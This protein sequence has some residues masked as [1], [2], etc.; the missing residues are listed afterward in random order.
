MTAR[1]V[2]I[3][4]TGNVACGKS[5]VLSILAEFGAETI[6]ADRV[7]HQ[8][9]EPD[10]PLWQALRD[11]FGKAILAPD[12]T[13]DRRVLG[14]IVF[15]DP[16]RLAE[17]DTLTH[18]AVAAEIRRRIEASSART[19]AIDAVKLIE[20]GLN[21]DCDE[22]WLV[23]CNPEQ[24]IARLIARNGFS[25]AEAERRVAAQPPIESKIALADAIVDN[26]GSKTETKA[27]VVA[28]WRRAIGGPLTLPKG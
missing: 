24:E 9:I 18:P 10:Q 12:R 7:Y 23:T 5:L 21:A 13:I 17:L 28:A 2:V 15:S 27:Q 4:V 14:E 26:S 25:R 16:A 1:P 6:D 22:V 19:I 11:H 20:G 3:G 8:L